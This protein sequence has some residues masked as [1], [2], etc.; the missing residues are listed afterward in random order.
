[1]LVLS[2]PT[3]CNPMNYS[4]PGSSVHEILQVRILEWVAKP[5]SRTSSQPRDGICVSCFA[6][7]F[8][9]AEPPGS[10]YIHLDKV[11]YS[12]IMSHHKSYCDV[13]NWHWNLLSTFCPQSPDSDTLRWFQW[14][15]NAAFYTSWNLNFYLL[16]A[17]WLS[18]AVLNVYAFT[19]WIHT[20]VLGNKCYYHHHF[21]SKKMKHR[22]SE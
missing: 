12:H 11:Y 21:T 1:M 3:H 13:V 16:S 20:I 22:E 15:A 10:P 18:G 14:K 6:G 7:R 9:T 5:S 17:N 8:F 4:P 2:C 19:F